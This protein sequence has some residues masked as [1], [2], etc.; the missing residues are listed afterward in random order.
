MNWYR[1]TKTIN[2]R[3]YLYE[4]RTWREGAKV[5]TQSRSLGPVAPAR[6]V[7]KTRKRHTEPETPVLSAIN[8]TNPPD[9]VIKAKLDR[10]KVSQNAIEAEYKTFCRH[11]DQ[12]GLAVGKM[13]QITVK[14]GKGIATKR[15]KGGYTITV[16]KRRP[17]KQPVRNQT[18]REYRRALSQAWLDT[19][20]DQ[21]PVLHERIE[22]SL[23]HEHA[24]RKRALVSYLMR[25]KSRTPA[26]ALTLHFSMSGQLSQWNRKTFAAESFGL[27]DYDSQKNWR[28]GAASLMADIMKDGV[29][30]TKRRF[31]GELK[32][33]KLA[34]QAALRRYRKLSIVDHLNGRK[35]KQRQIMNRALARR[36]AI[37]ATFRQIETLE[38]LFKYYGQVL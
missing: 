33:A 4:Q 38:P 6:S 30:G 26:W 32:K 13:P 10:I 11:L 23:N 24:E 31:A 17:D 36:A 34:E 15:S 19:L 37:N 27:V 16:P 22:T 20:A 12:C 21:H 35:A 9:L 25:T 14:H 18:R 2:G 7:K 3:Q 1:V 5:R 8:T 29:G 28:D